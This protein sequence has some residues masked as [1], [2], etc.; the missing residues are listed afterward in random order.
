MK[1]ATAFALLVVLGLSLPGSI[2][3]ARTSSHGAVN[4]IWK[5]P[6]EM[7]RRNLY[8]GPGSASLAPAPPFRFIEEDTSATTPK[9]KVS[10]ARNVEW[11]VKLGIESQSETVATRLVWAAGYF[12]EESYYYPRTRISNFKKLSRGS[13][14]F[15]ASGNVRAARF[16]PRRPNIKR[17]DPWDWRV[18]PFTGTKELNGLKVMMILLN[19]WDVKKENNRVL[20]AAFPGQQRQEFRYVVT[21]LGATLGR[22]GALGEKRSKNNVNDYVTSKFIDGVDDGMVDFDSDLT[23]KGLGV[24]AAV[25]PPA[26]LKQ[27]AKDDAMQDIPVAHAYWIGSHLAR[28]SNNQLRDAFRAAHHDSATVEWYV[29]AVRN[30]INE[31]VRLRDPSR[32]RSYVASTSR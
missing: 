18:N 26:F 29:R 6:G 32:R 31:L 25:F 14:S 24:L 8:Y 11:S 27:Q 4:V 5:N 19:N 3:V 15:D 21:D 13:D 23:P 10:D 9:F 7:S 28:L 17:G 1:K 12:A 2:G 20:V 16:E 22:A 30:R